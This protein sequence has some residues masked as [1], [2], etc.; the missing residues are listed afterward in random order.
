M[1]AGLGDIALRAPAHLVSSKA[2]RYWLLKALPGWLVLLTGEVV[3]LFLPDLPRPAVV[4]ALVATLLLAA[5][6]LTVMPIWRYRVH[7]WEIT[8]DAAYTQSGWLNQER[9]LAPLGRV[10]TVDT[11]RGPFAQL[12]GLADV[13]ITTASSRGAITIHALDQAVADQAVA[14]LTERAQLNSTDGT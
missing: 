1:T 5:A 14:W 13:T 9:R 2:P 6:H 8:E 12:L 11:Q 3:A 4:A 10:Q 7:R